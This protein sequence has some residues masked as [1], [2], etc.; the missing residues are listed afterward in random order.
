MIIPTNTVDLKLSAA[1]FSNT[2]NGKY[3]FNPGTMVSYTD[4]YAM[5][6]PGGE[7]EYATPFM[8][9]INLDPLYVSYYMN[10]IN[11]KK[12]LGF[13]YI[14]PLCKLQF[15]STHAQWKRE[16]LTDRNTYKLSFSTMQNITSDEGIIVKEENPDGTEGPTTIN[17][18]AFIV[19][20]NDNIPYRYLEADLTSYDESTYTFNYEF[21]FETNDI[22]N[23]DN[24]I[25]IDNLMDI[26]TENVSYGYLDSNTKATIYILSKQDQDYGR[27]DA[28][29]LIPNISEYSLSNKYSVTNGLDFFF[30]YSHM[31]SSTAVVNSDVD[32]GETTFTIKGVPVL[33]YSYM[34]NE[35]DIKNVIYQLEKRKEYINYCLTI[36]E[37]SFGID[38]KFFNTYGPSKKFHILSGELINRVHLSLKFRIKLATNSDKYIK[39]YIIRDIKEYMED[40]NDITDLHIPN[41]ITDITNRYREQLVYFEFLDM[42]GYGPG[43]QHILQDDSELIG[44]VPEFLNINTLEDGTPDIEITIA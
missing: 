41:L 4:E 24:R 36:L 43:V 30:N 8:C 20:Y 35:E 12:Y 40:I 39:D 32:T 3:V 28:E 2:E 16:F 34:N 18:R 25:R 29:G 1:D 27:D 38:F 5:V 44:V 9:V 21:R 19:L 10:I 7:F 23:T 31:V 11:V 17:M 22:L 33:R 42:N 37:D 26:N 6:G 13:D 15:I 14:N